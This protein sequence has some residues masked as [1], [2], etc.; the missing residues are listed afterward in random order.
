MQ[1]TTI[2]DCFFENS[3]SFVFSNSNYDVTLIFPFVLFIFIEQF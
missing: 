3:C 2:H 1:T